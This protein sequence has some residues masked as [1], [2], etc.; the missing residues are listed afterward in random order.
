MQPPRTSERLWSRTVWIAVTVLTLTGMLGVA[1][2]FLA[3]FAIHGPL[4]GGCA[5]AG[6]GFV[7]MLFAVLLVGGYLVLIGGLASG[8]LILFWRRSKWGPRLLIPANL[9][10]L[11]FFYWPPLDP[12]QV[13][14]ASVLLVLAAA[15]AAA[16]VLLFWALLADGS[17]VVRVADL[18]VFGLIALPLAWAGLMGLSSDVGAAMT[19]AP[20][21]VAA[22]AGC[23]VPA[24]AAL[25]VLR[26]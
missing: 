13:V 5:M 22:R 17:G 26:P 1:V 8:G 23:S 11:A 2:D 15:P 19:P 6:V 3:F 20:H 4:T 9:L 12:G 10:S 25:P 21:L 14:W 16:V 24:P 18:L 7:L